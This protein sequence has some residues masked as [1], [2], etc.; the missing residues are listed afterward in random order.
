MNT[1]TRRVRDHRGARRPVDRSLAV[2]VI[3][4]LATLCLAGSAS[5]QERLHQVTWAH[6]N[7]ASV[8]HFVVLV[9]QTEGAVSGAREVNVGKPEP[10]LAGQYHLFSAMIAFEPNEYLAVM[11]VGYDGLTSAPS[12]WGAMPPTRPGQ[13][14]PVAN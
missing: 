8:S 1:R 2:A 9:S 10:Q 11:A 3:G 13:P 12:S 6:T 4:L 7:P 5:A 14:L